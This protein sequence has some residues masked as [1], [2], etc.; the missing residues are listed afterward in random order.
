MTKQQ[1]TWLYVFLAMFLVPE[2]LFSFV[3]SM[4]ITFFGA[5][6]QGLSRFFINQQFIIDHPEYVLT[7]LFIEIV[8]TLG[9]LILNLKLNTNKSRT[10]VTTLLSVILIII[11]YAFFLGYGLRNGISF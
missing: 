4:T 5:S 11:V 3:I 2:I 9:L 8:G 7:F 6:F 1:K 10:V